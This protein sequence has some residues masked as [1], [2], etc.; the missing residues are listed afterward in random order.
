MKIYET[1][2]QVEE[3]ADKSPVTKADK[4]A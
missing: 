3:K 2:F 4:A 1:D